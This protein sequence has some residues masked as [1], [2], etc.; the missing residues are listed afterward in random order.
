MVHLLFGHKN[1][2]LQVDLGDLEDQKE[3]LSKFLELHLKV[4]VAIKQNKLAI[5]P[6]ATATQDL[7]RV[8]TKFIYHQNLNGTHWVSAEGGTVKI[9]RFKNAK[10]PDKHEKKEKK[11][12]APHQTPSQSWGL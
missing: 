5:E 3:N 2:K 6:E 8:V 11:K 4:T 10:K 12:N 7:Q 9:N 1:N